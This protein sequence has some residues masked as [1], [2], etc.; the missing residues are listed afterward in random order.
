MAALST[1]LDRE[2]Q[3]FV[4][5]RV[6]DLHRWDRAQDGVTI[7]SFE[8][9]GEAGA[10]QRWHGT[11]QEAELAIGLPLTFDGGPDGLSDLDRV[12]VS[13]ADVM[14]IAAAWSI[15]PT[16]LDGQPATSD[17]SLARL[18]MPTAEMFV[19]DRPPVAVDIT[20]LI[21]ADAPYEEKMRRLTDRLRTAGWS[22]A[23]D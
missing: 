5:H 8:Y 22:D 12:F 10:V 15:D 1:A 23:E 18:P 20:D 21:A 7:R 17:L 3:L 16:S 11:T 9:L 4:T 14:R 19:P 2:V 6:I 13:E